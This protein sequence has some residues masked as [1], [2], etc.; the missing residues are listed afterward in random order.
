LVTTATRS[1]W[2]E[3]V[4]EGQATSC[5]RG[6]FYS[7]GTVTADPRG[8]ATNCAVEALVFVAAAASLEGNAPGE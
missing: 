2:A 5:C 7:P 4:L 6:E 8:V 1:G 3:P